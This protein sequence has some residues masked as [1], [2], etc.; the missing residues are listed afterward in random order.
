LPNT[1]LHDRK[2]GFRHMHRRRHDAAARADRVDMTLYPVPVPQ[3][4]AKAGTFLGRRY[5]RR[6]GCRYSSRRYDVFFV[7]C[8]DVLVPAMI[9][10]IDRLARTRT[11]DHACT[12]L[13]SPA[14][15]WEWT[16]ICEFVVRVDRNAGI[17]VANAM[18]AAVGRLILRVERAVR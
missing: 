13:G 2:Q 4:G 1:E 8:L 11:S 15:A 5:R 16:A 3:R 6:D 9:L 12:F 14:A 7:L 10:N 18:M 17:A